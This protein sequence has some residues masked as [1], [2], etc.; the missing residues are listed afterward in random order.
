MPV[1]SFRI[2]CGLCSKPIALADDVWALDAEWQR[3][4]PTM[5]GVLACQDC[6]LRKGW[7]TCEQPNGE[8]VEGHIPVQE[9]DPDRGDGDSWCHV[10]GYNTRKTM[11]M[12]HPRSGLLQ[13]AEEYLRYTAQRSGVAPA[14]A[15]QLRA[16]LAEWDGTAPDRRPDVFG[17]A[18]AAPGV[19]VH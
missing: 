7:G 8:F 9:N 11:A 18:T 19:D 1:P 13:G 4:Y 17:Q 10:L 16:L 15:E 2:R 3:R 12:L 6:A 5:R 14:V